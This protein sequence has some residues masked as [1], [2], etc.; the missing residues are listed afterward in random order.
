MQTMSISSDLS[1]AVV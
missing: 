1:F